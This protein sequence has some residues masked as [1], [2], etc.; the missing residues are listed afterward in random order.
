MKH[1]ILSAFLCLLML[2]NIFVSSNVFAADAQ[3]NVF[4]YTGSGYTVTYKVTSQ[5]SGNQ[6]IDVNVKNT[7]TETIS[8]WALK[9]DAKGKIQSIW[10][11]SICKNDGTNYVIKNAGYNYDILSGQSVGFGYQLTGDNLAFPNAFELCSHRNDVTTGYSAELKVTNDWKSGFLGDI[12]IKNTTDTSLEA[13]KLSF[14]T[15]FTINSLWNG[16]MN[17]SGSNHY[18]VCNTVSN[19]EIPAKG[20][21]TISFT[22]TKKTDV[23]PMIT[24]CAVSAVSINQDFGTLDTLTTELSIFGCASFDKE[25]GIANIY[26]QSTIEKGQFDLF[27]SPDNTAYA[28][29]ATVTDAADYD[30]TMPDDTACLYFK[31]R[32]TSEDGRTAES[33]VFFLKQSEDG[34]AAGF[35]DT[36]NEGVPDFAEAEIGTD[37]NKPDTDADGLTDYQEYYVLGTDPLKYDSV[38][39]GI[40]DADADSDADGLSNATEFQKNTEPLKPD[41]DGDGLKDGEELNTY[42]T[43]PLKADTD[44]DG[45]SDGDEVAL[46]L[47]PLSAETNGV[48]DAEHLFTQ[49]IAADSKALGLVNTEDNPFEL[50]LDITASGYAPN[51]LTV[52]ESGYTSAI[53]N[54]AILGICPEITYTDTCKVDQIVLKFKIDAAHIDNTGSAFAA[55]NTEFSGVK[56]YNIFRYFEED[57]LLLP[58]ETQVDT[59]SN[60]ISATVDELGTFCI[61]DMEV[62]LQ[63]FSDEA[64]EAASGGG[65]ELLSSPASAVQALSAFSGLMEAAAS[66]TKPQVSYDDEFN[67]VFMYDARNFISEDDYKKM[68]ENLKKSADYIFKKSPKAN[69]YLVYLGTLEN[70]SADQLCYSAATRGYDTSDMDFFNSYDFHDSF[71]FNL[72]LSDSLGRDGSLNIS[73]AFNFILNDKNER[74]N[75]EK[76]VDTNLP[77]FCFSIF[78]Q[79]NV[80]YRESTGYEYL[81][82]LIEQNVN[83]SVIGAID[84]C[85]SKGYA[86]DLFTQT[87]G[88]HFEDYT[89][90]SDDVIRYIYSIAGNDDIPEAKTS[91][92]MILSTGLQLVELDAPITLEYQYASIGF[93]EHD[94]EKYA[95]YADTDG[96]GL[97]DFEEI[98]MLNQAITTKN[99]RVELPTYGECIKYY[100]KFYVEDGLSRFVNSFY[101]PGAGSSVPKADIDN[102]LN[103]TLVLPIKSDP[104]SQNGDGDSYYDYA[105]RD[106][107]TNPLVYDWCISSQDA[108]SVTDDSQY[109]SEEYRQYYNDSTANAVMLWTGNHVFSGNWS[110]SDLY[111][112]AIVDYLHYAIDENAVSYQSAVLQDS[113]ISL[114]T[115]FYNNSEAAYKKIIKPDN[116]N[117]ETEYNK[118]ML[119]EYKDRM[120]ALLKKAYESYD[121]ASQTPDEFYKQYDEII[122]EY[123]K[124]TEQVP[125]LEKQIKLETKVKSLDGKLKVAS[126]IANAADLVSS[127]SQT[128]NTNMVFES[129]M[130]KL[131]DAIYILDLLQQ[132]SNAD[133]RNAASEL[134][135]YAE[136]NYIST[137]NKFMDIAKTTVYQGGYIAL[138]AALAAIPEVGAVLALFIQGYDFLSNI[139]EISKQAEYEYAQASIA[140]Y[141]N[142]SFCVMMQGSVYPD[143]YAIIENNPSAPKVFKDLIKA[144]IAAENQY[145]EYSEAYPFYLEWMDETA[146]YNA[147]LNISLL[148][149]ILCQYI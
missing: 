123:E 115:Q 86:I 8:D 35:I 136:N 78:D 11:G 142:Q 13:W 84:E 129:D 108:Y 64:V 63:S 103:K 119:S 106:R 76:I 34:Y 98:D 26:W 127:I 130:N 16:T 48:K 57:N 79:K 18:T 90:F 3:T 112:A 125:E 140:Y 110:R 109:E 118:R 40:S 145:L 67:V 126:Y 23:T 68:N 96:D 149:A 24:N 46:G 141:L 28:C 147:K 52:M 56:R 88:K 10:N 70:K 58:V 101:T 47:N 54:D 133:L 73:D 36:D 32:Q 94:R 69:V 122:K 117:G 55:E 93:T 37:L 138:T 105:E 120:K 135:E 128:Y 87:G 25:T 31:I 83:V 121:P 50:S 116:I 71:V 53:H 7:G 12:T 4:T 61:I 15:N 33:P 65:M 97:Y 99:G 1:K 29:I 22:G 100:G 107:I 45:L 5:W 51:N 6:M 17:P 2:T 114:L 49:N 44:G 27:T 111:K 74:L 82:E 20:S 95:G 102:L 66:V 75:N 144:R 131:Y 113:L 89:N 146:Q 39:A 132:S 21:V 80:Y 72:S 85:Y 43:D 9:Y 137:F 92:P 42:G 62:F 38:T 134:K 14:D 143:G 91:Y 41:S 59:Q 77:T 60:T 104:T 148:Q 124:L 30:Y 19:R 81:D 139:S